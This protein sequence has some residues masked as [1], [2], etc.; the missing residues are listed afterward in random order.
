MR[1]PMGELAFAAHSRHAENE[2]RALAG[3]VLAEI[4]RDREPASLWRLLSG[5]D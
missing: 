4:V 3:D 2:M 5:R 1:F